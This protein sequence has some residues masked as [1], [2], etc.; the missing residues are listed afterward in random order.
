MSEEDF[1]LDYMQGPDSSKMDFLSTS[2][3][4]A[5]DMDVNSH[6]LQ[7]MKASFFAD[8]D[9]DGRSGE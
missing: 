8:D 3:S 7:L 4:I 9:Y 6:K 1:S 5:M 2:A